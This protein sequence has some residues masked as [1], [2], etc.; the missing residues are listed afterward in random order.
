MWTVSSY[1]ADKALKFIQFINALLGEER[2]G[3]GETLAAGTVHIDYAVIQPGPNLND[4]GSRLVIVDTPGLN[5][6]TLTD[7][8]II[9]DIIDWIEKQ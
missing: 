9:S 4:S 7:S 3:V 5:D 8:K 6:R 1:S 2:M